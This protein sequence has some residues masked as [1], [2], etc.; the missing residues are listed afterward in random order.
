M[1]DRHHVLNTKNHWSSIKEAKQLRDSYVYRID[2]EVHNDIHKYCPPVPLLGY[3]ALRGVLRNINPTG[4]PLQDLDEL[5]SAI[6]L[7]NKHPKAHPIERDLGALSIEAIRLQIPF[8]TP[9]DR[10]III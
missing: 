5:C 8:F 4:E 6:D 3:Y 2:R 9:V 10:T 7:T 1:I